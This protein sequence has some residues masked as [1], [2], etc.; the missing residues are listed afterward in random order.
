MDKQTNKQITDKHARKQAS[1]QAKQAPVSPTVSFENTFG[2]GD[3]IE[4]RGLRILHIWISNVSCTRSGP[5][6]AKTR[7]RPVSVKHL[8]ARTKQASKHA[9]KQASKH[10]SK[11]A[12][13]QARKTVDPLTSTNIE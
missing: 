12:S 3:W 6:R 4:V 10:A 13:K 11:Q 7:T 2:P 9:C 5:M 8:N 1:K